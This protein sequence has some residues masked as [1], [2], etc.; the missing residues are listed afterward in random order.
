MGEG[1]KQ[2]FVVHLGKLRIGSIFQIVGMPQVGQF[3]ITEYNG[4]PV[5]GRVQFDPKS[6]EYHGVGIGVT[7]VADHDSY[8]VRTSDWLDSQSPEVRQ[9]VGEWRN[10]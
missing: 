6:G 8:Y 3:L 10:G 9:V 1:F 4:S 2:N 7:K 5:F